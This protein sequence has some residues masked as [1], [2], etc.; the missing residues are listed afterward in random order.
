M[1]KV[2]TIAMPFRVTCPGCRGAF[3][4]GDHLLGKSVRCTE[5]QT[6]FTAKAPAPVRA[7]EPTAPR[8]PANGPVP[9]A[10]LRDNGAPSPAPAKAPPKP[11]RGR[12]VALLAGC[13][14]GAVVGLAVIATGILVAAHYL[15]LGP[16]A[17]I[18]PA[19]VAV[20]VRMNDGLAVIATGILGL[21]RRRTRCDRDR[22]PGRR[23]LPQTR[24]EGGHRPGSR[25]RQAEPK[26]AAPSVGFACPGCGHGLRAQ[27]ALAGKRVKC[28]RCGAA[29]SV[30]G[31]QAAGPGPTT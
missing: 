29:V 1:P 7:N 22:H 28:P 15:K 5:C 30:P 16:K 10:A 26:A 13:G 8:A 14:G 18:A 6:V 19:A 4:L 27:A 11:R 17:D 9:T 3:T 2:G 25:G 12:K 21:R 20:K 31:I 24:S 23:P